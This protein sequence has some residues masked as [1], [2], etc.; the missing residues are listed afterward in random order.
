MD[1]D[2]RFL[3]CLQRVSGVA[4]VAGSEVQI[5]HRLPHWIGRRR[6]AGVFGGR[7]CPSYATSCGPSAR[8][9]SHHSLS[10]EGGGTCSALVFQ[11]SPGSSRVLKKKG[12]PG[13]YC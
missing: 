10:C 4:L 1:T 2:R 7:L 8:E 6:L 11:R 12:A 5:E 13:W 9:G 3:V